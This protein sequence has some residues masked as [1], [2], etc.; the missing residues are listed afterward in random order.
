MPL[1]WNLGTLTSWNPL[2]HSR[3][4]KGLLYLYLFTETLVVRTR[5]NVTLYVQCLSCCKWELVPDDIFVGEVERRMY[6]KQEM[7]NK[8]QLRLQSIV[9]LYLSNM[10]STVY[11][12]MKMLL[13]CTTQRYCYW[14]ILI[15]TRTNK[16]WWWWCTSEWHLYCLIWCFSDR[17]S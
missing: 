9:M 11:H 15:L 10:D 1:S 12:W 13:H 3:P 2:G 7:C 14:V 17:A 6:S 5:F 8:E 16:W 4:V